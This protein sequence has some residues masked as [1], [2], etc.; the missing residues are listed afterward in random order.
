MYQSIHRQNK[1]LNS[2]STRD[3]HRKN[4]EFIRKAG[5]DGVLGNGR[6][7]TEYMKKGSSVIVEKFKKKSWNC[8]TTKKNPTPAIKIYAAAWQCQSPHRSP[9]P[10]S[11]RQMRFSWDETSTLHPR[12]VTKWLLPLPHI[13][14]A[15][16]GTPLFCGWTPEGSDEEA[17]WGFIKRIFLLENV[18]V[19]WDH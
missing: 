10:W 11:N 6:N 5:G 17:F 1:N 7:L 2:G 9:T 14:K 16:E 8:Q 18:G 4:A 3:H 19:M 15:L 12:L 13:K